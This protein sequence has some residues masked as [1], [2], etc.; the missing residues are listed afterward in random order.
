MS[1][2]GAE[3]E[4]QAGLEVLAR[5]FKLGREGTEQTA[6]WG[7]RLGREAQAAERERTRQEE[8][9]RLV[10]PPEPPREQQR[11]VRGLSR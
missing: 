9:Q 10:L 6:A 5:S 1:V 7:N 3:P 8:R 11:K 2:P 4:Q